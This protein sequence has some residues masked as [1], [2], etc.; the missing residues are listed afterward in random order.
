MK[1]CLIYRKKDPFFFSIE[2]VFS[3]I[4]PFLLKST[5][6]QR[7]MLPHYSNGI[8]SIV[9]NLWS[10][11]KLA[12]S[13]VYHM[14]GDN[15]YMAIVLP[16]SK[17]VL[18]IHD[19]N[20]LYQGQGIKMKFI[21][22]IY[23]QM[24]VKRAH[25]V[26]TISEK[27]RQEIIEHSHCDPS[28]VI[29]IPNPLNDNVYF[30]PKRFNTDCP[31]ILF[32]GSTPNKN[33]ERVIAAL[34]G[35]SCKLVIIGKINSTQQSILN[36]SG[37]SYTYIHGLSEQEMS[38]QYAACD[39]M[40]FPSTYEGFGLPIIEAQKA[41]RVVITSNISPMKEVAGKGA[42]LVDPTDVSSITE[43]VLKVIKNED[44]REKLIAEGFK[45]IIQ[46]ESSRVADR[47]KSVYET[48]ANKGN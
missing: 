43:A 46:Y 38:D 34:T 28:K 23:L 19:C 10:A 44:Q 7:L 17:T 42:L 6:L 4:E 45:N 21:K 11:R 37:I 20:Y 27:S 29:V 16:R 12:K 41:G 1:V 31:T 30:L 2:K 3:V 9:K 22:W 24:P 32:I 39:I 35:F 40:L 14:T 36:G 5:M 15:N 8:I 18:T 25:I 47:Y 13:D 26:T 33:L 48:I